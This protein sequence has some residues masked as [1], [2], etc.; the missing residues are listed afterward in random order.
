[1]YASWANM[2]R[3][4][5]F[6]VI[7]VDGCITSAVFGPIE[8]VVGCGRLQ[9]S[10]PEVE[11]CAITAEILSPDG[12]PFIGSAGYRMPVDGALRDLPPGTVI[13]I[14]GFGLPPL[15]E[16]PALLER[17]APVAKWLKRQHQAGCSVVAT[18][19]GNFLLGE[20]DLL[21]RRKATTHWYYADLFRER[22]P[23]VE[24][25]VDALLV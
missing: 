14:P 18:C 15:S 20:A 1:M 24:V 2:N 22:Y 21:P 3:K 4:L 8:L 11:R 12:Q 13:F 9:V 25:D 10:V 5:H 23:Q 16:M 7:A 6:S 19:T 17:H